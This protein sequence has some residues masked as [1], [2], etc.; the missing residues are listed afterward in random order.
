MAALKTVLE[1]AL[2]LSDDERGELIGQLLRSLEPDDGE[3]LTADEWL[4]AWSGELDQR[5]REVRE[6]AV[7]LIDGD[8]ALAGVRRSITARRP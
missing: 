8:E 1:Q 7:E 2:Q 4:A 6:G 3:D 5:A